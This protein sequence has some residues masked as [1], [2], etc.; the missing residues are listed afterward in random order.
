MEQSLEIIGAIVGVIYLWLEY[1]ASIHLWVVSIIMPAIY[2]VVF[3]GAGLYADTAIN[4]YY[5]LIALYGWISWRKGAKEES[6]LAISH[7]PKR[8]WLPM[9]A[10]CIALQ[11]AIWAA[12][13]YCTDSTVALG[14]SI[15]SAISIVAMWMLARKYLEQWIVWCVVDVLC[16]T[17]YIYT[18][19]YFT[20]ALYG[21]YVVIAILGYFK[22]KRL[23]TEQYA[24]K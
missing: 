14:N 12:L 18:E 3:Y 22:W 19:L 6:Q 17:L 8:L 4:I 20:A 23:M 24:Y 21:L 13:H 10:I 11:V 1:K 2:L 7:T 16:V 5:L 9:A 15:T